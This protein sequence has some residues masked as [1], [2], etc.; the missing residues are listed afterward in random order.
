VPL[1]SG[2]RRISHG[3]IMTPSTAGSWISA[4]R[5]TPP[6]NIVLGRLLP[7]ILGGIDGEGKVA[8]R[9]VQHALVSAAS[10]VPTDRQR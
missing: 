4:N 3:G 2:L 7:I 8:A 5:K 9:A 1:C 6:L 10:G